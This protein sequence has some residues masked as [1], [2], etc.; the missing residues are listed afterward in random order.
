MII[1]LPLRWYHLGIQANRGSIAT[2][3]Q[4]QGMPWSG[5]TAWKICHQFLIMSTWK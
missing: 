2:S 5:K 4:L 3:T 1:P